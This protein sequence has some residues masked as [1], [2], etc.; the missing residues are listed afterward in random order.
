MEQ[1]CYVDGE[2]KCESDAYEG[3][4]DLIRLWNSWTLGWSE[5]DDE[6][7][8]EENPDVRKKTYWGW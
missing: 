5:D 2:I 7:K 4:R 1:E 6:D 3:V 8:I